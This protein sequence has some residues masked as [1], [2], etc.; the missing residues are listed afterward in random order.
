MRHDCFTVPYF[1]LE[2]SDKVGIRKLKKTRKQQQM[3]RMTV[4]IMTR[5]VSAPQDAGD[6][7]EEF[8][9]TDC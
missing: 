3:M 5:E 1:F 6:T 9:A 2:I 8:V 4:S 7:L